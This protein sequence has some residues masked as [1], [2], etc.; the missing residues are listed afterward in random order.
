M[1]AILKAVCPIL[2]A[3]LTFALPAL[4]VTGPSSEPG[5]L[6]KHVV[7]VL[8]R[9]AHGGAF[10]SGV[11]V[12]QDIVLTAAHCV[13]KAADS[14]I[15]YRGAADEP[16][17]AAVAEVA[18]HPGF[19]PNAVKTRERSVDLA[20]VRLAQL[21]PATLAA[22][23]LAEA[24][25]VSVGDKFRLAGF[26]LAREGADKTGGVL[27]LAEL[28]A[29]TPLSS[30]LLWAEDPSGKGAGACT[31]DSGAPIFAQDS[32]KVVAITAWAAG[33][34]ARQCGALTQ[35]VLVAPQ[36]PWITKVVQGWSGR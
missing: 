9:T 25:A 20:L 7:M 30:L 6:A 8:E 34:G 1:F 36:L 21:L 23:D 32:D 28:A 2:A 18:V 24:G 13:G 27:R 22:A 16:V 10:C 4:A 12:A 26:G 5:D 15:Y 19:R 11:V 3:L 31:G 29:R 17:L 35:G 14:R 33:S